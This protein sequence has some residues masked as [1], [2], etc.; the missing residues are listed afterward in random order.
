MFSAE[1]IL[2]S[3][4]AESDY[5][6]TTMKCRYPKFIH[7]EFMTHRVFSR[8]ASSSRAIPVKKMLEEARSD[9]LRAAPIFWG[10]N[11]PGMSAA[12]ELDDVDSIGSEL[13]DIVWPLRYGD[14]VIDL[15][16]TDG[17]IQENVPVS[18][19][20]RKTTAKCMWGEAACMAADF[21]DGLAK[22]GVHKQIVNRILEPFLHINVIVTATE[23]RNFFGLRLAPDA[24]PE[25]R[26]LARHMFEAYKASTP[27]VLKYN[28]WHLP[29]VRNVDAEV[30]KD[31]SH[32]TDLLAISAARC[33]RIS[34]ESFETGRISSINEDLELAGRL[35]SSGHMS[36]FEHQCT[37]DRRQWDDHDVD[38]PWDKPHLHGN[39][40]GFIQNRKMIAGE[41][42]ATMEGF[43]L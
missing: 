14:N 9:E 31:P 40:T 18:N 43:T 15:V 2:D 24:Q 13:V 29:F 10:K 41:N 23:W 17:T 26:E 34:Y 3:Q 28:E 12:E 19:L 7:G 36:P 1:V 6:V 39:L 35:R 32:F 20:T 33:A 4:S 42:I 22:L 38:G 30:F 16:A 21:A 37:P 8:N 5:R 11:Q 27:T 25:M